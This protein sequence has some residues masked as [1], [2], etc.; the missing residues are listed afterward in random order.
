MFV[1]PIINGVVFNSHL[2]KLYKR[3]KIKLDVGLYGEKLTKENVSDEHLKP[4]SWGG[5]N[6]E[7]NIALTSIEANCRRGNA[8]IELFLTYGMLRNYLKQFIDVK[9]ADFDGNKY[10]EGVRKTI[11]ELIDV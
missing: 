10:I 9:V 4:K 3:G 8:P 6:E 2:K 5:T 11:K 7:S 1:P